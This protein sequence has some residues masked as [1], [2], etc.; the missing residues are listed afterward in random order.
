MKKICF[1][2]RKLLN[3]FL[4]KKKNLP[5][6]FC[7]KP[8]NTLNVYFSLNLCT[9]SLNEINDLSLLWNSI[10][11]LR[12]ILRKERRIPT[13]WCTSDFFFSFTWF[14]T[15]TIVLSTYVC[16]SLLY[17]ARYHSLNFSTVYSSMKIKNRIKTLHV[18]RK[19]FEPK[20]KY[21]YIRTLVGDYNIII[22]ISVMELEFN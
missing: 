14:K 8:L 6:Q 18:T 4:K 2:R 17:K 22:D 20:I 9:E 10:H 11:P 21:Y 7:K 15:V 16:K 13:V 3:G 19:R 12:I 1:F 5:K